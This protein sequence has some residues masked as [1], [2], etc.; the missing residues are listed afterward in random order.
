[1]LQ[2]DP[3]KRI[4][5]NNF[6]RLPTVDKIYKQLELEEADYFKKNARVAHN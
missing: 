2:R 6:C 1:M 5:L 3:K 4:L